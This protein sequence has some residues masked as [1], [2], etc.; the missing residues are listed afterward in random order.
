MGGEAK[1]GCAQAVEPMFDPVP[2]ED[3]A[4]VMGAYADASDHWVAFQASARTADLRA[5]TALVAD[6]LAVAADDPALFDEMRALVAAVSE[7][8]AGE[9]AGPRTDLD[10]FMRRTANG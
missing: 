7:Q 4:Y 2:F 1:A 5:A 6:A 3:A 8:G 10:S 9:G